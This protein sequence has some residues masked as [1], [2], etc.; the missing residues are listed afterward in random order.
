MDDLSPMISSE[1]SGYG[2]EARQGSIDKNYSNY[3]QGLSQGR[4]LMD[5]VGN[6][7]ERL[8]SATPEASAIRAKY[9]QDF[10]KEQKRISL[11][12]MRQ[13]QEDNIKKL[14]AANQMA[15]QEMEINRQKELLKWQRKQAKKAARG[16]LVGNVLGIVGAVGGAVVG[17]APGAMVG[18]S[19]GQGAGNYGGSQ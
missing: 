16:Q 9:D 2:N 8:G 1:I 11:G 12:M 19:V 17:G 6:F 7:S 15:D 3:S 14:Q 4:G 5:N 13:A 18:Y 10:G